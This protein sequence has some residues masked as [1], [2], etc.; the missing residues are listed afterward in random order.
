MKRNHSLYQSALS[1]FLKRHKSAV[2][3][4]LGR[5]KKHF[6]TTVFTCL[7]IAVTLSLPILLLVLVTNVESATKGLTNSAKVSVYLKL[8]TSEQHVQNLIGQLSAQESIVKVQYI[9]PAQGL[10]EFARSVGFKHVLSDLSNNPL[11]AVLQISP[12]LAYQQPEKLAILA[13]Q[14]RQLPDVQEVQLDMSWIKRLFA[15]LA[16]IKNVTFGIAIILGLGTVIIVSNTI[17]YAIQNYQK[18]IQVLKLIGASDSLIRRP[19]LY[20]GLFY[21]LFGISLAM[22]IVGIFGLALSNVISHLADT[23]ST[24][25]HLQLFGFSGF[26]MLSFFG[27]VL[28]LLGAWIIVGRN[29][30]LANKP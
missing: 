11:P 5:L 23:F 7:V 17:K 10:A 9:S 8:G 21:G 2:L 4:S 12:S 26:I 15:I 1:L 13:Q 16:L 20:T 6:S 24:S 25:F 28:G 27:M 3:V 30:K 14:L 22:V 19:F 29:I 18:E